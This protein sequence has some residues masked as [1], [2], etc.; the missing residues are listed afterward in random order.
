MTLRSSVAGAGDRLRLDIFE[1]LHFDSQ[2]SQGQS[3]ISLTSAVSQRFAFKMGEGEMQ[4]LHAV[5]LPGGASVL[6]RPQA[7]LGQ[8]PQGP[9]LHLPH[10]QSCTSGKLSENA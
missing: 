1:G 4:R 7:F 9:S 3:S 5:I 8:S 10:N 2:L 6:R